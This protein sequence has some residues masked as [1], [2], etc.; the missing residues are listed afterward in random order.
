MLNIPSI[1]KFL[2]N[3]GQN[4]GH[5]LYQS[6]SV[7]TVLAAIAVIMMTTIVS[8][9]EKVE[10]EKVNKNPVKQGSIQWTNMDIFEIN[11]QKL[12]NQFL[13]AAVDEENAVKRQ[14]EQE[15]K[16]EIEIQKAKS[17]NSKTQKKAS[18]KAATKKN[19]EKAIK[20]SSSN[21]KKISQ[22]D[23]DILTRI[24]EAEATGHDI[25]SKLMVANVVLNRVESDRFPDT[26]EEVVFQNN[27]K[28]YQFSPISDKRYYKVKVTKETKKAVDQAL[29]GKDNSKGAMFFAARASANPKN[30]TWFDRDLKYLFKYSGHEFFTYK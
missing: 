5:R 24:V 3:L 16:D 20:V 12:V 22:K 7:F 27:G 13:S 30:M 6:L 17:Q 28:V 9:N 10:V 2:K 25:K 11:Q 14:E 21:I 19:E 18:Q 1:L 8:A 29:S 23:Y 15:R 26:I 4:L